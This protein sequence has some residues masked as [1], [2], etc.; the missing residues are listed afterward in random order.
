MAQM[1]QQS[2][3]TQLLPIQLRLTLLV[4]RVQQQLP[5]T[6]AAASTIYSSNDSS[7]IP[8]GAAL[9]NAQIVTGTGPLFTLV[10]APSIT[11]QVT[12]QDQNGNSTSTYSAVF[13]IQAQSVGTDVAYGLLASTTNPAFA[14]GNAVVY[15]TIAGVQSTTTLAALGGSVSYNAPTNT[16]LNSAGDTFTISRNSSVTIPVTYTFLVRNAGSATYA[17]QQKQI[18]TS[19]GVVNFMNGQV[20]WR[21]SAI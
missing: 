12:N 8:S 6:T 14:I 13:N 20:A 7:V 21:T 16:T 9:G 1:V 10:S 11:K 19:S 5:T 3:L 18:N 4:L 17:V 2:Q 15:Q